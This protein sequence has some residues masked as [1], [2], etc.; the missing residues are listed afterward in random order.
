M[1]IVFT[2]DIHAHN[3]KDYSEN[4]IVEWKNGYFEEI[5]PSNNHLAYPMVINS[6]L[7]DIANSLIQIRDYCEEQGITVLGIAGDIFHKRAVLDT[8]VFNTIYRVLESFQRKKILIVAI[9]GNHDRVSNA[10][11]SDNS[12]HGL[13]H[14][15]NVVEN[16]EM[17]FL[18]D[19]VSMLC[20]PYTKD[21]DF[22]LSTIEEYLPDKPTILMAHVG[23][24]GGFVGKNNYTMMDMVQAEELRYDLFKY[25]ILGH[26]HKP[27]LI[28]G[29]NNM[30]YT[31]APLQHNFN[32][33]GET[34]GFWVVDT[35]KRF[36]MKFVPIKTKKFLTITKET[37]EDLTDF[38]VKVFASPEKVNKILKSIGEDVHLKL[39]IQK[40]F[41]EVQRSGI[42]IMLP[43]EEIISVFAEEK[44]KQLEG[45]TEVGLKIL[46]EAKYGY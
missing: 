25:V 35:D 20:I 16:P 45:V 23:V 43:D 38:Y 5:D 26:Y 31:G 34:R 4:K 12:I 19:N 6:R 9:P 32:D 11:Y 3:F 40:T 24:T 13:K 14:V 28:T 8:T 22:L 42:N 46:E 36:N 39:E 17:I 15:I 44:E 37:S 29:T 41:Q 21:K 2:A 30:I 10:H 27:Q 1:K 33:E 18:D 7:L